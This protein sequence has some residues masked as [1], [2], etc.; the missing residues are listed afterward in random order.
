[1]C[2]LELEFTIH[3]VIGCN[4]GVTM[5]DSKFGARELAF[6]THMLLGLNAFKVGGFKMKL[7]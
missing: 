3:M 1:M 2:H 4:C 7:S 6:G 5:P